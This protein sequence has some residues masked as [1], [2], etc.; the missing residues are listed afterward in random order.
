M[1][2][3][4]NTL[5]RDAFVPYNKHLA[6]GIGVYETIMLCEMI[7]KYKYFRNK[8]KLKD[9]EF[10]FTENEIYENTGVIPRVQQRIRPRLKKLGLINITRKGIPYRNYYS[11]NFKKI[12]IILDSIATKSESSLPPNGG[13]NIISINNNSIINNTNTV[14]PSKKKTV[15]SKISKKNE[16]SSVN[17]PKEFLNLITLWNKSKL[18]TTHK[19][20]NNSK[21]LNTAYKYY[22]LLKQGKFLRYCT[23]ITPKFL[24]KIKYSKKDFDKKWTD[25][26]IKKVIESCLLQYEPGYYPFTLEEKKRILPRSLQGTFYN[27]FNGACPSLFIK[28]YAEPPVLKEDDV[29]EKKVKN[30]EVTEMYLSLF[31]EELSTREKNRIITQIEKLE[32]FHK[33]QS[34]LKVKSKETGKIYTRKEIENAGVIINFNLRRFFE[35]HV[36]FLLSRYERVMTTSKLNLTGAVWENFI[37]YY[38]NTYRIRIVANETYMRRLVK[39]HEEVC[40]FHES[41]K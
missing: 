39:E 3:I 27:A 41:L 11:I 8:N 22:K 13:T 5:S 26:E 23:N 9:N 29:I 15:Q 12:E 2:R 4:L 38:Y 33:E 24:D 16:Q 1:E 18:A 14:F 37:N 17:F 34:N 30:P 32:K 28:N 40:S 19:L 10:F 21:T 31:K 36:E 7:S 20:S 25:E 35:I 6:K